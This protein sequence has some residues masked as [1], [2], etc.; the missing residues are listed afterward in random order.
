MVC[1]RNGFPKMKDFSRLGA[2]LAVT[3]TLKVVVSKKWRE[4]DTLL[5]H[6]TNREYHM[7]Y[8]FVPFPVTLDDL[9]GH[10][11]NAGLIKCNSTNT[12]A[13]LARF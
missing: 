4:I 12:Y 7:A 10:S 6:T 13:T 1:N 9:E 3:Y 2:L 8:L 5:P 11:P